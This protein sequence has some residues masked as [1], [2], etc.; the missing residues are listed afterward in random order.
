M[1]LINYFITS[2]LVVLII[3][4][5]FA[6]SGRYLL[7][8]RKK[9]IKNKLFIINISDL[10]IK[11][12][13]RW[14]IPLLLL[15][16]IFSIIDMFTLFKGISQLFTSIFI[17]IISII[18]ERLIEYTRFTDFY[19]DSINNEPNNTAV[20]A[21]IDLYREIEKINLGLIQQLSVSQSN[22]LSQFETTKKES[23][24]IMENIDNYVQIQYSECQKLLV[25]KNNIDY[26]FNELIKN[27][28]DFCNI[29]KQ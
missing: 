9:E 5:G 7:V 27:I 2:V 14:H 22:L 17:A 25:I 24:F 16:T 15:Q 29:F 10:I 26:F 4:T 20:F 1:N 23:N 6:L 18:I 12:F 21:Y 28:E 13:I 11:C 8:N 3:C 19:K